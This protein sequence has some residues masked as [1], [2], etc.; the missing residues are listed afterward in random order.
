MFTF[1]S[2]R[3]EILGPDPD[4]TKQMLN[5]LEKKKSNLYNTL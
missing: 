4:I 2:N 5:I 3:G 1:N